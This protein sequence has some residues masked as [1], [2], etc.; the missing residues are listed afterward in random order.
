[1]KVL[2]ILILIFYSVTLGSQNNALYFTSGNDRVIMS[3][4]IVGGTDFTFEIWFSFDGS[5]T[6]SEF[7]R[8]ITW[9]N[10]GTRLEIGIR[11]NQL[12]IFDGSFKTSSAQINDNSWR[13]LAFVRENDTNT[14]YLDGTSV[15]VFS[16]AL[17]IGTS[18][19]LGFFN[20]FNLF[21]N[22]SNSDNSHWVGG[23]DEMRIWS[24]A[25]TQTEIQ[26]AM[27]CSLQGD[28]DCL[29]GYWNFDQGTAEGNNSG[30]TTLDDLHTNNNDGT[31]VDFSLSGSVSNWI[32]S[33]AINSGTCSNVICSALP[34]PVELIDFYGKMVD[35]E[36]NLNWTTAS[37]LNNLGF[38]IHKS[39]NGRDWQIID[40]IEGQ[41]TTNEAQEY[42][43]KDLNSY[44]RINYYRLKQIDFDG[45]FEFSKTIS[46]EYKGKNEIIKVYPNPSNRVV[47]IQLDNPLSQRMEI[48]IVDNV[49]RT[50]WESGLIEDA[51]NWRKEIEI[52]R[53]G[54]YFITTQIG[55]E[56]FFERLLVM[57][58]H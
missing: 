44:A 13:H 24:R 53:N 12:E 52:K 30:I 35:N 57:D 5:T 37:E 49:G 58:E 23:L 16:K 28:E 46:I 36:I 31:L 54:I 14:L 17:D 27:G 20:H 47:N 4:P 43:Y 2:S 11:G 33:G 42:Q 48:R 19:R 8:I 32:T 34:L 45:A 7:D 56:T 18:L 9:P 26:S 41:G 55:N 38:E 25:K 29:I 22:H 21:F 1:M 50:V 15:L 3:S 10:G 40:F 6:N 51:L 39:G